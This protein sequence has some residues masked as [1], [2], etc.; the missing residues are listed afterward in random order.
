MFS[1]NA[2]HASES[3]ILY[4][5]FFGDKHIRLIVMR[6]ELL[7]KQFVMALSEC[8]LIHQQQTTQLQVSNCLTIHFFHADG[9]N[10]AKFLFKDFS[11]RSAS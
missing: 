7:R 1:G 6:I 5:A 3:T 9:C 4:T 8:I 2:P 10:A 11:P